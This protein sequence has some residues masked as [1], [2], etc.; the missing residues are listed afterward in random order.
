MSKRN[1]STPSR[2]VAKSKKTRRIVL[3]VGI[4]VLVL[5]A[6][7]AG[8]AVWALN[9]SSESD[10]DFFMGGSCMEWDDSGEC[11]LF[12]LGKPIIYLYPEQTTE[13]AVKLGHPELLTTTY[14]EYNNGWRV[15]A[16]PSGRLVDTESGRELYALYWEG[17][18]DG[19]AES[20]SQDGFVVAREQLVE[21]LE[22]KLAILG[23][24]E[25]EAD[26]FIIYWLPRLREAPYSWIR[27]ET[28]AEI[29]AYM[30][31]EVTPQPDTVIRVVMQFRLL[32]SADQMK[33]R[34]QILEPVPVREGFTVV[35]WGGTEFSAG[36]LR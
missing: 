30:P 29:D 33:G 32:D 12:M 11:E 20:E 19:A 35:E 4:V 15:M 2:D 22:E 10:D 28:R 26:E 3:I 8:V 9:H 18:R 25:R 21:F 6:I 23:L 1:I 16:E 36:S 17:W 14:P 27:F 5:V 31:L 24:N 34:E 7:A 13:V